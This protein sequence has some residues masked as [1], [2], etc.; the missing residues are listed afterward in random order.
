MYNLGIHISYFFDIERINMKRKKKKQNLNQDP[1]AIRLNKLKK[2]LIGMTFFMAA[3]F[4]FVFFCSTA[5][6]YHKKHSCFCTISGQITNAREA[7]R[8]W[9]AS[10]DI[11]VESD[12]LFPSMTISTDN[13]YYV[14]KGSV[15]IHYDPRDTKNYYI[16]NE[17]REN[18]MLGVFFGVLAATELTVGTACYRYNRKQL[19]CVDDEQDDNYLA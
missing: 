16:E 13:N 4:A 1:S 7:S 18:F 3:V 2:F 11:V 19:Y 15:T 14:K 17:N 6:Y 5:A 9:K 12:G 10:G 8:Y